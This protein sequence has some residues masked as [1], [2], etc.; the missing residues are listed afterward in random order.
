M[1]PSTRLAPLESSA[2]NTG[3]SHYLWWITIGGEECDSQYSSGTAGVL[4]YKHRSKS[5]QC[6]VTIGGEECDSSGTA[7]V[8]CYKHRSKSLQCKVTIGGEECD[9]SDTAGVLCCKHRSKSLLMAG[10]AL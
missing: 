2:T 3:V 8:L 5:L 1:I 10:N 9:L 7:G 4:C 6:K